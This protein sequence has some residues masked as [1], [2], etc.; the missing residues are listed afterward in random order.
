MMCEIATDFDN[1]TGVISRLRE[2]GNNPKALD[3]CMAPGGF[4][5]AVLRA[6]RNAIVCGIT[7]PVEDGGHPMTMPLWETNQRLQTLWLDITMLAAEMGADKIPP[8]HPEASKF[9]TLRPFGGQAFDLVFCDGNVLRT[10][11]RETY[12]ERK[13][14]VRLLTSQL[15]LAMQRIKAGGSLII[16]FHKLEAVDTAT[17]LCSFTKFSSIQL[18]KPPK[19]HA[20]RSSFYMIA[21]D[22]QPQHPEAIR[23]LKGW[24]KQWVEMTMDTEESDPNAHLDD[25]VENEKAEALLA[26]FGPELITL[27]RPIWGIQANAL[28][29]SHFIREGVNASPNHPQSF[30]SQVSHRTLDG[31]FTPKPSTRNPWLAGDPRRDPLSLSKL[32]KSSQRAIQE[33]VSDG[34][35]SVYIGSGCNKGLRVPSPTGDSSQSVSRDETSSG[36]SLVGRLT[37]SP[38][39]K[40]PG[41]LLELARQKA[42]PSHAASRHVWRPENNAAIPIRSPSGDL[43]DPKEFA[44]ITPPKKQAV[45]LKDADGNEVDLASLKAK[46][47]SPPSAPIG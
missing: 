18:F 23:A 21:K 36:A 43:I 13:E 27:G 7:L 12:R 42:R 32:N 8:E 2:V 6:I 22:V 34:V 39:G 46:S 30:S 15:I 38:Q 5:G 47:P 19:H 33:V 26:T 24:K 41:S 10:Q 40:K 9:S 4:A 29:K 11:K 3:L 25:Q 44:A 14:R 31:L 28:S 35:H 1:L 16:R 17:I 20:I 45:S 37:G